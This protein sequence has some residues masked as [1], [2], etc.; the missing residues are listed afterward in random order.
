MKIAGVALGALSLCLSACGGG[1]ATASLQASSKKPVPA[2]SPTP[3]PTPTPT[4]IPTAI[5]DGL[6]QNPA[7]PSLDTALYGKRTF[8]GVP[9]VERTGNRIW[10]AFM[11]DNV[12]TWEAPGNYIILQFS[13]NNGATWSREYYLVPKDRVNDRVYD[14]RLW[15]DP[16]GKLW[17]LYAQSGGGKML[18]GQ[19]GVWATV[20]ENPG[21]GEPAF[22]NGFWMSD[23]ENQRP[24]SYGGRWYVPVQYYWTSP[25]RFPERIGNFFY[26]FDWQNRRLGKVAILP[27]WPNSDFAETTAVER[28]DGSLLVQTRS[29][30]G[31][32]Q[33]TTAIGG[34]TISPWTRWAFSP[35]TY[36]R[37]FLGRTPSGRLLMVFNKTRTAERERSDLSIAL[38]DDDGATWPLIH[39]F[40]TQ[41]QISY[42]DVTFKK[43]GDIVIVYD[44]GRNNA[45]EILMATFTEPATLSTA[46]TIKTS[47]INRGVCKIAGT[48][49]GPQ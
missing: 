45:L 43:N 28:R 20:V 17:I 39:T 7:E 12:A 15:A 35:T 42:P 27:K 40:D 46:P 6:V 24:F 8:E 4:P 36:S 25:Q 1:D 18:D 41:P 47:V 3:T 22:G 30:D 29:L 34:V 10:V 2:P 37:H 38:S 31:I 21:T 48:K 49:C 33:A 5:N 19:L 32:L 13:D 44:H 23:G 26:E 11:G 9:S 16:A 14:V